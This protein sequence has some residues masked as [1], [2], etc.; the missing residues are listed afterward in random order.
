[1]ADTRVKITQ[2]E[3]AYD[4]ERVQ[5][6]LELL[7]QAIPQKASDSPF[8]G[9]LEKLHAVLRED[10]TALPKQ[11]ILIAEYITKKLNEN[12]LNTLKEIKKAQY[13]LKIQLTGAPPLSPSVQF[14]LGVFFGT[15]IGIA[16]VACG[17][18]PVIAVPLG[19]LV[20]WLHGH[21]AKYCHDK[22]YLTE[23]SEGIR[24]AIETMGQQPAPPQQLNRRLS[25]L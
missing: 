14:A 1:M 6:S 20:G 24:N 23:V 21:Y 16:I 11:K 25:R 15:L 10:A 17:G 12:K 9:A 18:T 8:Q 2:M 4:K 22:K 5:L 3:K 19:G 7:R 13:G